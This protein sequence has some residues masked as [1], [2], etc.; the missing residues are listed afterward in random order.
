MNEM[1]QHSK[2]AVGW[3]DVL[4][5]FGLYKDIFN[6]VVSSHFFGEI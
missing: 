3:I 1:E 2:P 6:Y 4:W 5:M